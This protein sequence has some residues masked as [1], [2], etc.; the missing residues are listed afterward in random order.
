MKKVIRILSFILALIFVITPF[1]IHAA[2]N[3]RAIN[4]EV[5]QEFA[6]LIDYEGR[7]VLIPCIYKTIP[8]GNN[9]VVD[10][11][12]MLG[13]FTEH[14]ISG[15]HDAYDNVSANNDRLHPATARFNCHSYAWYS[16][17]T[18]TNYYMMPDPSEYYE[19]GEYYE[20]S[21]PAVGDIICYMDNNGTSGNTA[22]D[23][24]C[25]SGIIVKVY[26]SPPV[27]GLAGGYMVESKWGGGGLYR[28]NGYQCIYTNYYST[29]AADY[30]KFY[31]KVGHTH[32]F[33]TYN[34]NGNDDYHECICSCGMIIHNPH[35]WVLHYGKS[36]EQRG[37]NYIPEYY[38]AQC[39]AFSLN[40]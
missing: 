26:S 30:L 5:E 34:D 7:I 4:S 31:R 19:S 40:P 9:R 36:L 15:F 6:W 24:N 38:C 32:N 23:V 13:E 16:Q 25:H 28:H 10:V 37:V 18:S 3:S 29:G 22:D 27:N 17:N 11:Q 33:S 14:K 2:S 39:G 21:A 35:N 12:E 20:V 8:V 1:K